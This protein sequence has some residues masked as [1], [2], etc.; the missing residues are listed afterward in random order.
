MTEKRMLDHET[1]QTMVET[2]QMCIK[3]CV[4][5]CPVWQ[6]LERVAVWTQEEIDAVKPLVEKWAKMLGSAPSCET[7]SIMYCPAQGSNETGCENYRKAR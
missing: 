5:Q 2:C 6:S 1:Y 3:P 7:C 4:V